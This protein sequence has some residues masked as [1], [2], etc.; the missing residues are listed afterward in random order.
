[1]NADEVRQMIKMIVDTNKMSNDNY[2][3]MFNALFAAYNDNCSMKD[4]VE[5]YSIAVRAG[6]IFG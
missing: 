1:M 4:A 2:Y 3:S 6:I 5:T